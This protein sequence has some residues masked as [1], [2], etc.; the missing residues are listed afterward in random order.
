MSINDDLRSHDGIPIDQLIGLLL[1][2]PSDRRVRINREMLIIRDPTTRSTGHLDEMDIRDPLTTAQIARDHLRQVDQIP[3][4]KIFSREDIANLAARRPT[5]S[6]P[7]LCSCGEHDCQPGFILCPECIARDNA[8]KAPPKTGPA[9]RQ[10]ITITDDKF[11]TADGYEL[12]H[13]GNIWTDGDLSFLA[14]REGHPI[15]CDG[16][17]LQGHY[18]VN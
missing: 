17:R 9:G 18:K 14:D 8:E 11:I 3:E 10:L 13:E 2:F 12:H 7:V 1:E 4:Y 6:T 5:P 15:D 16:N